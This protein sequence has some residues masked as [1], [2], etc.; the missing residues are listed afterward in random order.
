MSFVLSIIIGIIILCPFVITLGVLVYGKRKGK[1]PASLVGKAADWT[2]PFLFFSVFLI[3]HTIFDGEV[4]TFVIL[5]FVILVIMFAIHERV[6]QKDFQIMRV[7]RKVWRI[8][9]LLLLIAYLALFVF[10]IV[11][12]LLKHYSL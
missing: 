1:A 4:S 3:T 8:S 10:G 6:T 2:T 5:P 12:E 11:K 7:L 9:F